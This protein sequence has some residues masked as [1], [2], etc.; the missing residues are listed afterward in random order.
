MSAKELS[1]R[2]AAEKRDFSGIYVS[3]LEDRVSK[4]DLEG[5]NL[6]EPCKIQGH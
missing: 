5:A 6:Q 4:G 1:E 2:Y 3:G